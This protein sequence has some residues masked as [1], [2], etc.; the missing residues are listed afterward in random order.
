[1]SM[2]PAER[3]T[4]VLIVDDH[5]LMREALAAALEGEP[6]LHVCGSAVNGQEAL[7]R[8]AALR[9]QVV[10]MD[11]MMPVRDGLTAITDILDFDPEARILVLTSA[12]GDERIIQ[13]L[14][15]G[16]LGYLLKDAERPQILEGVRRVA[17]GQIYLPPEATTKLVRALQHRGETGPLSTAKGGHDHPISQRQLHVLALAASGL[18]DE[19]IAARLVLTATTVRVHMHHIIQKLC[20]TDRASAIAWYA[21]HRG[22]Q[23]LIS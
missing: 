21:Q 5:P 22:E 9:P 23:P 13:A 19:Q 20:V 4:N 10:I 11:L 6:D 18:T 12:V 8:Y 17:D 2:A 1:M 7:H 14:A 16:A 15:A 3:R